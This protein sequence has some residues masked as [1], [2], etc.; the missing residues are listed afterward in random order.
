MEAAGRRRHAAAERATTKA[1][2]AG[3]SS[4]AA[5]SRKGEKGRE[6][7]RGEHTPRREER[8]VK[9]E[10]AV[11]RPPCLQKTRPTRSSSPAAPPPPR[12]REKLT[13]PF[14]LGGAAQLSHL[15]MTAHPGVQLAQRREARGAGSPSHR[16]PPLRRR[17]SSAAAP[18]APAAPAAA[19]AVR[20]PPPPAG[21]ANTPKGATSIALAPGREERMSRAKMVT[22]ANARKVSK[23]GGSHG[24]AGTGDARSASPS[25]GEVKELEERNRAHALQLV[26][27]YPLVH[28]LRPRFCG[29]HLWPPMMKIARGGRTRSEETKCGG[30]KHQHAGL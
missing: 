18:A 30:A 9:Q 25:D 24:A 3:A 26:Q 13:A 7:G 21:D 12:A 8:S 17:A 10:K 27:P 14:S 22:R 15:V 5:R 28:T 16:A 11:G 4:C 1:S 23:K 6:K 20:A 29:T 19:K 2:Q